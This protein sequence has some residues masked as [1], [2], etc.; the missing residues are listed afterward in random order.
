LIVNL[1]DGG[2]FLTAADLQVGVNLHVND[3][4]GTNDIAITEAFVEGSTFIVL[5][6][7]QDFVTLDTIRS[8]LLHINTLGGNDDVSVVGAT[9]DRFEA[10]LGV[11]NDRFEVGTSRAAVEAVFDG[12]PGS[13]IFADL[14]GNFFNRQRRN[15]FEQFV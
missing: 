15:G 9:T 6:S 13:D 11:G 14:G 3:P 7:G 4:L 12:G 1:G 2:D 8:D 10:F 5:G